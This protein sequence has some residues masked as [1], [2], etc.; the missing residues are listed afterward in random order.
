MKNRCVLVSVSFF[1][2]LF[3]LLL[4]TFIEG[5]QAPGS[6]FLDLLLSSR[7]PLQSHCET[8]LLETANVIV[9]DYRRSSER[10]DP[11]VSIKGIKF[12][13]HLSLFWKT[14]AME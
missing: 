7:F 12:C 10:H 5:Y 9:R 13:F 2:V 3:F 1:F 6:L 14:V 11:S 4:C 8:E